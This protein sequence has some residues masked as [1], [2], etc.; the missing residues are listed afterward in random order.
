MKKFNIKAPFCHDKI[1]LMY[2]QML[3]VSTIWYPSNSSK[4]ISWMWFVS[5]NQ[6]SW[7]DISIFLLWMVNHAKTARWVMWAAE[8]QRGLT[9]N[10]GSSN[11]H[12]HYLTHEQDLCGYIKRRQK[13]LFMIQEDLICYRTFEQVDR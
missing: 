12:A 4:T 5:C 2:I 9:F 3:Y 8:L 13:F 6:M 1:I 11:I 7:T 10:E